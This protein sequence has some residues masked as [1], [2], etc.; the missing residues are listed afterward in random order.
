MCTQCYPLLSG[1][2]S[3]AL[4]AVVN[5]APYNVRLRLVIAAVA[6][7]LCLVIYLPA[8]ARATSFH[9]FYRHFVHPWGS[10][11]LSWCLLALCVVALAVTWP[12]LRAGPWLHR[13][14][15]S[16]IWLIPLL[17]LTRYFVWL[18]QQWTAR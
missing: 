5:T 7:C 12:L 18:A 11:A 17:I 16:V 8:E 4:G 9:D 2:S 15:A 10:V 1:G 13:I 6:V 3:A 14:E